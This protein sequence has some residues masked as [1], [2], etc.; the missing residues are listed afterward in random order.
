MTPLSVGELREAII[1][2]CDLGGAYGEN[3]SET[4]SVYLRVD[5][6]YF[7]LHRVAVSFHEGRF[8]LLLDGVGDENTEA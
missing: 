2:A 6:N 4:K 8:I 1:T 5:N 7:P 3:L